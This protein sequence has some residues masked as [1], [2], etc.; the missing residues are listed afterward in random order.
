[1]DI[2]DKLKKYFDETPKEQV[3]KNWEKTEIYDNV[4]S[5]TVKEFLLLN[6]AS[7]QRELLE[8]YDKFSE[9]EH[10]WF[11]GTE[12]ETKEKF[13]VAYNCC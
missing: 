9:I 4:K 2:Y 13:L 3:L 5:P 6:V 1:M 11:I 8:A 10:A 12:E 7:Q